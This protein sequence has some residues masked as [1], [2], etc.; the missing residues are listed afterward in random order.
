MPTD[1]L[2]IRRN[3][4]NALN[5][6]HFVRILGFQCNFIEKKKMYLYV[7]IYK[8]LIIFKQFFVKKKKKRINDKRFLLASQFSYL[9]KASEKFCVLSSLSSH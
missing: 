5:G 3:V 7:Y 6:Q 2:T 8:Q 1:R 9:L 4:V